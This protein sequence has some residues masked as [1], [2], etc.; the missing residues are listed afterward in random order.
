LA[1]VRGKRASTLSESHQ[2]SSHTVLSSVI[3]LCFFETLFSAVEFYSMGRLQK[4]LPFLKKVSHLRPPSST[5]T[6]QIFTNLS[7]KCIARKRIEA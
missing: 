7:R 2:L 5:N 4:F 6:K 1:Q 3:L